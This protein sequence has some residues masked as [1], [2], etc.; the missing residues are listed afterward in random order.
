M[1]LSPP[2]GAPAELVSG[3]REEEAKLWQGFV[4]TC[5]LCDLG[6][7]ASP[8]L[9]FVQFK[10]GL[11][12]FDVY[13]LRI[14]EG[15]SFRGRAVSPL[16]FYVIF[17]FEQQGDIPVAPYCSTLIYYMHTQSAHFH[18]LPAPHVWLT[19]GTVYIYFIYVYCV[20]FILFDEMKT[21]EPGEMERLTLQISVM[22]NPNLGW[23]VSNIWD[24]LFQTRL[25]QASKK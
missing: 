23:V 25:H 8:P 6:H 4:G 12:S 11:W 17:C 3:T 13:T 20:Y 14:F 19:E 22:N 15:L 9:A 1:N 16:W 10:D 7:F 21:D 5:D 24:G 2:H 18:P